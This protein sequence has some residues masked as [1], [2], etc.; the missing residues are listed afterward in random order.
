MPR[1]IER[2]RQ[3]EDE[4]RRHRRRLARAY[5]WMRDKYE[6]QPGRFAERWKALAEHWNFDLVNQVIAA[7][8]EWYPVE[9]RL[10]L[11]PRSGDYV[12]PGGRDWRR[13]PL[14]AAWVLAQ[15][16]PVLGRPRC[17]PRRGGTDRVA[18]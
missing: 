9:R 16:P 1:F 13:R 17:G 4:M 5:E 15:F 10:P 2:A 11:N 8:N 12:L 3:I 6:D 14:D 18:G 7:H